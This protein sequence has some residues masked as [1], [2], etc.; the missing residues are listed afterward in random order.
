MAKIKSKR[1][2]VKYNKILRAA[3]QPIR[4]IEC[5]VKYFECHQDSIIAPLQESSQRDRHDHFTVTKESG[6]DVTIIERVT[7]KTSFH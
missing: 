4:L 5:S 2:L 1:R 3:E 7:S 6:F